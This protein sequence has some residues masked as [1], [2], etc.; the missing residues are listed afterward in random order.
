[1]KR[2]RSFHSLLEAR[3]AAAY[4]LEHAIAATVITNDSDAVALRNVTSRVTQGGAHDLY[5]ASNDDHAR[6]LEL[7]EAFDREPADFTPEWEADAVP[8]LSRLDPALLP[9]CPSCARTLPADP[10]LD[11]CPSCSAEVDVGELIVARHG[12]DALAD[13]YVDE[14]RQFDPEVVDRM[15]L[16]CDGCGYALKNLGVSGRCPECGTAY[17]K[18]AILRR[19]LGEHP[20]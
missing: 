15:S 7:L 17:D 11:A 13:C 12:P 4:L 3:A 16:V 18:M 20:H 14:P 9:D 19:L 5:I 10:F 1:M 8:D 2:V 6:S